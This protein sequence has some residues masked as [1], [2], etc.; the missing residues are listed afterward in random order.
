MQVKC[1][2]HRLPNDESPKAYGAIAYLVK[3]VS[4]VSLKG[5]IAF[6]NFST[7]RLKV[8]LHCCHVADCEE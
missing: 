1:I 5:S 7:V 2:I 6:G 4:S 3:Q 8:R